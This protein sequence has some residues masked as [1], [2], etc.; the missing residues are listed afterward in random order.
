MSFRNKCRE[1]DFYV[2]ADR[3]YFPLVIGKE[4]ICLSDYPPPESFC[5]VK[6]EMVHLLT[7]LKLESAYFKFIPFYSILQSRY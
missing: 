5:L 7:Y 4:H 1:L 6:L 2:V 3:C